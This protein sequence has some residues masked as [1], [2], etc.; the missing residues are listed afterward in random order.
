MSLKSVDPRYQAYS[1]AIRARVCAVCL[2]SRD[3]KSC[4]LS[5]RVCAIEAHLPRLVV[6]LSSITSSRIDE[7]E[8]AIRAD[9]C[10]QCAH[11]DA[12]GACALREGAN[13]ALEAYLPLVLDAVEDVNARFLAQLGP[14][15]Y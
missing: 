14:S 8:A 10:S 2:D 15:T 1:D 9:V 13:C 4:T 5:G 7:Y 3:D 6:A 12:Q 11:Q